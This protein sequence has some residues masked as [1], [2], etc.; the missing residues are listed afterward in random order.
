MAGMAYF[1]FKPSMSLLSQ[2]ARFAILSCP[3]GI[4]YQGFFAAIHSSASTPCAAARRR[5]SAEPADFKIHLTPGRAGA[6]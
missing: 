2:R 4:G 1:D 5:S 6:A 3:L